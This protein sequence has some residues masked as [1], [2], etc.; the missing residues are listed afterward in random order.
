MPMYIGIQASENLENSVL[1]MR[2][3]FL[4]AYLLKLMVLL[5][6]RQ[7]VIQHTFA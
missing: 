3:A 6:G 4:F 1:R 2:H 7:E 5:A